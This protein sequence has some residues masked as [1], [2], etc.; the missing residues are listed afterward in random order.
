M[1]EQ[2]SDDAI[3]RVRGLARAR[4]KASRRVAAV[5]VRLMADT[6]T[7]FEV[8][9]NR[10][11]QDEHQVRQ[12]L[13]DFIDGHGK[14]LNIMSDLALSMGAEWVVRVERYEPPEI[15]P[16]MAEAAVQQAAE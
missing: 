10:L 7:S 11:G 13:G 15:A 6:D 3:A 8:I 9:A 5:L 14:H 12:W 4:R 2:I 1:D 16:E